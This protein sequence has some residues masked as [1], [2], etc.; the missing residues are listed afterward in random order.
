MVPV[1]K[2]FELG[3]DIADGFRTL[4]LIELLQWNFSMWLQNA[5]LHLDFAER[6]YHDSEVTRHFSPLV[7]KLISKP[8]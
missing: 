1:Q 7:Q 6:Y 5:Y 2:F 3:E 8:P 4:R